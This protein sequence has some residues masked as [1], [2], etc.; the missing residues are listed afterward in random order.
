MYVP[1]HCT[2]IALGM[3]PTG[4]WSGN[5][6]NLNSWNLINLDP[7]VCIYSMLLQI[8]KAGQIDEELGGEGEEGRGERRERRERAER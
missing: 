6:C 1:L 5:S 3:W 2:V 7:L 4:T 8:R